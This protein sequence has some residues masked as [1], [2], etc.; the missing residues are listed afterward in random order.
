MKNRTVLILLGIAVVLLTFILF[1]ERDSMT[2]DEL[3]GRKDRVFVEFRREAVE[4]LAI[5]GASGEQVELKRAAPS[6]EDDESW[7]IVAPRELA[8]DDAAV[9]SVLSAID[10]LLKDRTV[11]GEDVAVDPTYGL[12]EPRVTASYTIRGRETGFAIGAETKDGKKVYVSLAD[13]PD[14]FYAVEKDF[15][16]S[17]NVGLDE[18]R[19][20]HLVSGSL[21]DAVGVRVERAGGQLDLA[22]QP[23]AAWTVV[24]DGERV[25]AAADQIGELLSALGNLKAASFVADGVADQALA[26]YGLDAPARAITITLPGDG[27]PLRVLFGEPCSGERLVHATVGGSGTVACVADDAVQLLDRPPERFCEMRAAAFRDEDVSKISIARGGAELVLERDDDLRRWTLV[28]EGAPDVEQA[29]VDE[30]LAALRET[31]ATR[32]EVG[33]EALAGLADPTAQITLELEAQEAP[34]SLS[35]W[36]A[37]APGEELLRR[38]EERAVLRLGGKLLDLVSADP[39]AFRS[40]T[41]ENGE[42]DDVVALE[43]RGPIDQRLVRDGD[44]WNLVEPIGVAGDG[45]SA[46]ELAGMLSELQAVRYAATAAAPEHG[47]AKPWA[48]VTATYVDE[49]QT[50]DGKDRTGERKL[51]LEIGAEADPGTRYARVRGGDGAVLVLGEKYLTAVSR[52]LAARD[53][54]QV[55]DGALARIEIR[56][57]ERVIVADRGDD[58]WTSREG[59]A[60]PETLG[61]LAADLGAVKAI[62]AVGFD[63]PTE[64]A[65]ELTVRTWTRQQLDDDK[66]A[67]LRI[68]G[69]TDDPD[70][71]GRLAWRDGLALTFALPARLAGDVEQL[72]GPES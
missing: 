45:A 62:R 43:I 15:F 9:R 27:D 21:N 72:L 59:G 14:E 40:R 19:D 8:A 4:A 34:I 29:A 18:L 38:G 11:R 71:H 64:G 24:K 44:D 36:S 32:L 1:V 68:G 28:G 12:V 7:K 53:L 31:R 3:A 35:L 37:A 55:D 39:L 26:E 56:R 42:R 41:I 2:T 57:G 5:R 61:R 65:A 50:E 6:A 69:P 33:D 66:P 17:M 47:L 20:K 16:D 23:G 25:A 58:G 63:L 60:S 52:P 48:V 22:R 30:L 54:L 49:K 46:R 67:T 10:F 51:V 13:E 70:E